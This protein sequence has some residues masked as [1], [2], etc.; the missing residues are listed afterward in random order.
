[1]LSVIFVLHVAFIP[2]NTQKSSNLKESSL[3][4]NVDHHE[5][6]H[7]CRWL[8]RRK[9]SIIFILFLVPV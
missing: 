6:M 5:E 8:F 1:V 9:M 3:I 2:V 7:Y 4:T